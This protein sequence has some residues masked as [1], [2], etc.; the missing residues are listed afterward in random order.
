MKRT[1]WN[2]HSNILRIPLSSLDTICMFFSGTESVS[3]F[4]HLPVN[5]C[6][7]LKSPKLFFGF[8][9]GC[10]FSGIG[11]FSFRHFSCSVARHGLQWGGGRRRELEMFSI[12][13]I[14][15]KML[16]VSL[17]C[18]YFLTQKWFIFERRGD[19][20]HALS[21]TNILSLRIHGLFVETAFTLGNTKFKS[22]SAESECMSLFLKSIG[23]QL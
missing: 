20:F 2:V 9:L 12:K 10:S 22:H 18:C 17:E 21:L 13:S 19:Y 3:V 7:A 6:S 15:I 23:D 16:N 5:T 1:A 14:L 11:F 4:R 8:G